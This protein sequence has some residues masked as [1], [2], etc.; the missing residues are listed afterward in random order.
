LANNLKSLMQ[1]YVFKASFLNYDSLD[2]KDIFVLNNG[3][4]NRNIEKRKE[5][6]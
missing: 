6:L 1:E 4:L 5:I 2:S 3:A